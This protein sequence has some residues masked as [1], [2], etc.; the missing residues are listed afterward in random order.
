MT[1]SQFTD[2]R[3]ALLGRDT[4]NNPTTTRQQEQNYLP[5]FPKRDECQTRTIFNKTR[6]KRKTQASNC[7]SC[8]AQITILDF[9]SVRNDVKLIKTVR[10]VIVIFIGFYIPV[11]DSITFDDNKPP[12]LLLL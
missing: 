3:T 8:T 7:K 6:A 4:E 12:L 1:H 5:S 11:L 2:Q 9:V 10:K